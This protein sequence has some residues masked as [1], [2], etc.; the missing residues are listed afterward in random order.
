M[1][2]TFFVQYMPHYNS[3][4]REYNNVLTVNRMPAGPLAKCVRRQRIVVDTGPGARNR[5]RSNGGCNDDCVLTVM[6][7]RQNAPMTADCLPN[8]ICDL[9]D[10]GYTIDT[11]L[12]QMYTQVGVTQPDRTF[13]CTATYTK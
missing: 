1:S 7:T 6:D 3:I 2:K 5:S 10:G 13:C 4:N 12:S 8:F 9:M 11:H